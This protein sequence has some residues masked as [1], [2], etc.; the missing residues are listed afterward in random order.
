MTHTINLDHIINNHE[1]SLSST[2][3][4][5][6]FHHSYSKAIATWRLSRLGRYSTSHI[7]ISP[8]PYLIWQHYSKWSTVP[9]HRIHSIDETVLQPSLT[10]KQ[11]LTKLNYGMC[12]PILLP[13]IQR[14]T[15]IRWFKL[16]KI[17]HSRLLIEMYISS[18]SYTRVAASPYSQGLHTTRPG[19]FS[20]HKCMLCVNNWAR[21]DDY[22]RHIF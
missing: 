6:L 5:G 15:I 11:F 12:Q 13:V 19:F 9:Y 4:I 3:D 20:P 7:T 16:Y 21:F 18:A 1:A 10:L 22:L 14:V 17:P 2:A 8:G